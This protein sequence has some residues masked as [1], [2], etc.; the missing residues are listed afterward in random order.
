MFSWW[1]LMINISPDWYA[2][3]KVSQPS[4]FGKSK[5]S[6]YMLSKKTTKSSQ[7]FQN[8]LWCTQLTIFFVLNIICELKINIALTTSFFTYN[9][10]HGYK[11]T[12]MHTHKITTNNM[13][14]TS[15]PLWK[16]ETL[17]DLN[18]KPLADLRFLPTNICFV[19]FSSRKKLFSSSLR[20][21]SNMATT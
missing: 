20:T 3:S 10:F 8:I 13:L 4:I 21:I 11:H 9:G 14:W 16:Y 19:S 1:Q 15:L 17:N 18:S 5:L 12:H 6:V 2:N 7:F